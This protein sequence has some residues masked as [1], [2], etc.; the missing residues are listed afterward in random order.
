T[1]PDE[2]VALGC[3]LNNLSQEMAPI[4]E[5][6]CDRINQV[7]AA[8]QRAIAAALARAQGAG[9]IRREIY[10]TAVALFVV[11]S[12]EGRFSVAQRARSHEV[13]RS[14]FQVLIHYL[15]SLRST[16]PNRRR[17]DAN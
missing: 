11:A 5:A 9:I 7:Y 6:F 4:D 12:V 8:W 1:G 13:L 14:S 10:S 16:Q 2:N 3:P 15:K 17:P